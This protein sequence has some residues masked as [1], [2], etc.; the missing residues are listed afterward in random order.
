MRLR[1][2]LRQSSEFLQ[3]LIQNLVIGG[4]FSGRA[5][6]RYSERMLKLCDDFLIVGHVRAFL[7]DRS[8]VTRIPLARHRRA[9]L[10]HKGSQRRRYQPSPPPPPP[11]DQPSLELGAVEAAAIAVE[12]PPP[13]SELKSAVSDRFQGWLPSYQSG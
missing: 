7:N 1:F 12:R 4:G 8:H 10:P 13:R 2:P 6:R 9:A 5:A 3:L 11:P